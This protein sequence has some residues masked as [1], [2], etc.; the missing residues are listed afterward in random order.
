MFL[1]PA[2][3]P[4]EVL[5]RGCSLS[6]HLNLCRENSFFFYS[7]TREQEETGREREG[8]GRDID[9]ADIEDEEEE[10]SERVDC[11]AYQSKLERERY[12]F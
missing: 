11:S 6:G 1:G 12:D 4:A 8:I 2:S 5:E 3:T 7:N 9:T 10:Q